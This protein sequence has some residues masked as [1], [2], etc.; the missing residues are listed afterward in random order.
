MALDFKAREAAF[1][2]Y[3]MGWEHERIV[4]EI[5]R[6]WPSFTI[7]M[8]RGWINTES[9]AERRQAADA[10]ALEFAAAL[11]DGK[12]L[13]QAMLFDLEQCRVEQAKKLKTGAVSG[14]QELYALTQ[15][16]KQCSD[17]LLRYINADPKRVALSVIQEALAAF[18]D[19]LR[20][21]P[22]IADVLA[23]QAAAVGS[24]AVRIAERYGEPPRKR[25]R[26]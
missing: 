19:G 11:G 12:Q 18:V 1:K 21:I 6:E 4:R 13:A 20:E 22:A 26:R 23:R 9:W 10:K 3:L 24:I 25:G 15:T 14:P 2:L 5:K 7:R 8:L 17:L 16:T